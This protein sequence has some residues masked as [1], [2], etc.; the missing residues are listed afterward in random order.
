V[1]NLVKLAASYYSKPNHTFFA[2][3]F[4]R[5]LT[6]G[7]LSHQEGELMPFHMEVLEDMN[8]VL[9]RPHRVAIG[10]KITN[11]LLAAVE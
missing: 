3:A 1:E 9:Q 8:Q 6:N 7:I 4:L 11:I 10:T 5:K 2:E